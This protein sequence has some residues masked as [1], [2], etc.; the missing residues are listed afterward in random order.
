MVRGVIVGALHPRFGV[1]S[2][3]I[4]SRT[5]TEPLTFCDG[6][7]PVF[8]HPQSMF[9]GHRGVAIPRPIFVYLEK[10]RSGGEAKTWL[11]DCTAASPLALTLLGGVGSG[12][13]ALISG[14]EIVPSSSSSAAAA[15]AATAAAT[16]A[17]SMSAERLGQHHT[18][19]VLYLENG[20]IQ[21]K[22]S[23]PTGA[24]VRELRTA[25]E[26][27]MLKTLELHHRQSS[28]KSSSRK[29]QRG[30]VA[31]EGQWTALQTQIVD[32]VALALSDEQRFLLTQKQR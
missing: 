22:A 13:S 3:D 4:V 2:T 25:L 23:G 27:S 1:L 12:G 30:Q 16:A 6:F 9:A 15:A 24:V 8:L 5:T 14:A 10:T 21:L 20:A 7:G 32:A 17:A 29:S 31:D 11:R 18:R 19:G 28:G 26:V